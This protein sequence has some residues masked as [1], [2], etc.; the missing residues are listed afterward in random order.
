MALDKLQSFTMVGNLGHGEFFQQRENFHSVSNMPTGQL[1]NDEL[2]ADDFPI[3]QECL[4][5]R[6]PHPEMCNPDG[7]VHKHCAHRGA[8]LLLG[9]GCRN[10]SVPPRSARRLPLS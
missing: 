8:V 2:M 1:P 7:S 4:E 3:D 10:L 5:M 6:I 9:I